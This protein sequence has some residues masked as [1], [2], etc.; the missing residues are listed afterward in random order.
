MHFVVTNTGITGLSLSIAA[1]NGLQRSSTLAALGVGDFRFEDSGPEP[2][3]W[4][5]TPSIET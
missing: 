2:H 3:G 5:F 4:T 1:N